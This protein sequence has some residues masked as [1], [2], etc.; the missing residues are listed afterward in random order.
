MVL[1]LL[2]SS[3]RNKHSSSR[4][5]YSNKKKLEYRQ[6]S[7]NGC[8]NQ[9]SCCEE[10]ESGQVQWFVNGHRHQQTSSANVVGPSIISLF[11]QVC[12]HPCTDFF[13]VGQFAV[14]KNVC[15]GQVRLSQVWSNQVKFGQVFFF[16]IFYSELSLRRTALRRKILE[17]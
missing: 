2:Y 13:A 1:F 15:F 5:V 14:R 6:E 9:I 4:L 10:T 8:K 17:P 11:N 3:Q 7:M 16:F 12:G